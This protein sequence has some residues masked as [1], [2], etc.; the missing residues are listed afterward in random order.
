MPKDRDDP[1]ERTAPETRVKLTATLRCRTSTGQPGGRSKEPAGHILE[2]ASL[3]GTYRRYPRTFGFRVPLPQRDSPITAR[4]KMA[5]RRGL[6]GASL[7]PPSGSGQMMETSPLGIP[8]SRR[9]SKVAANH[10]ERPGRTIIQLCRL[11]F[12]AEFVHSRGQSLGKDMT[13]STMNVRTRR[14]YSGIM[15]SFAQIK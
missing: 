14:L 5:L 15:S 6:R 3:A 13:R 7:L 11:H 1:V 9:V 4:Q 10:H 8:S 12:A 2:Q